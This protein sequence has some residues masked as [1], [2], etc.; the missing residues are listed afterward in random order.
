MA[1]NIYDINMLNKIW[2]FNIRNYINDRNM[3]NNMGV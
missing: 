3:L 2:V 1:N